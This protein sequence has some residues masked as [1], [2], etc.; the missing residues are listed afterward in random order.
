MSDLLV[1]VSQVTEL[2][3]RFAAIEGQARQWQRENAVLNE[4]VHELETELHREGFMRLGGFGSESRNF[5]REAL[6]TISRQSFLFWLKNPLIRRSV[7]IISDYVW[8][9]GINLKTEDEKVQ[10][11]IDDFM[12][13]THNKGNLFGHQARV[14]RDQDLSVNGNVFFIHFTNPA[15]GAVKLSDLPCDEID[16]IISNPQDASEPWFY[17][18][19]WQSNRIDQKSGRLIPKPLEALYPDINY[20]PLES[21]RPD[22][23]GE[24]KIRWETPLL[25]VSDG[26]ASGMKFAVPITYPALAWARAYNEYLENWIKLVKSLARLAWNAKTKGGQTAVDALNTQFN[27]GITAD[28]SNETNPSPVA[29]AM[30]IHGEGVDLNPIRTNNVAM[31]LEDGRRILLMVAAAMGLPESFFGDVSVGTLATAKSLDRPTE[32]RMRRRQSLWQD[33]YEIEGRYAM[34]QSGRA[35]S[36]VLRGLGKVE[37]DA[38]DRRETWVWS[39]GLDTTFEAQFP[40]ILERNMESQVNAIATA[41]TAN[42]LPIQA[43]DLKTYASLQFAALNIPDPAKKAE[44]LFG[45]DSQPAPQVT[46][47]QENVIIELRKMKTLLEGGAGFVNGHA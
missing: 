40:E 3:T 42:G 35:P 6:R 44:E 22:A 17:R 4:A 11:V 24:V 13:S 10:E 31:S 47:A 2:R 16:D 30:F 29:G 21:D 20:R 19:K 27:T 5:S 15:T 43:M 8:G 34:E 12:G 7:D 37:I 46:V 25:H 23:L 26:G 1:P 33:V 45:K 38:A 41:A 28:S 9:Q 18:R 39:E 32:L 14:K 36:G